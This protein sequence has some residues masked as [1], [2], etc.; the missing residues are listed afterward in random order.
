MEEEVVPLF[1]PEAKY[2]L[3]G[4]TPLLNQVFAIWRS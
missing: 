1:H 4:W 2:Y 3:E